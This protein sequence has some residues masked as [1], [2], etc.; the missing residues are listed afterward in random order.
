VDFFNKNRG[1]ISIFLILIMVPMYTGAYYAIDYIRF[2]AARD[3]AY[4]ALE[5]VGNSALANFC[6]PLHDQYGLFAMSTDEEEQS[7]FLKGI[8]EKN[9]NV[10]LFINKGFLNQDVKSFEFKYSPLFGLTNG[11]TLYNAILLREKYAAPYRVVKDFMVKL[12][13]ISNILAVSKA[14]GG[15]SNYIEKAASVEKALKEMWSILPS[16]PNLSVSD[17]ISSLQNAK[18]A[19]EKLTGDVKNLE[20]YYFTLENLIN[21]IKNPAIREQIAPSILEM[22]KSIS[23]AALEELKKS[24]SNDI[25]ELK[26][27]GEEAV[28]SY[29]KS[30]LFKYM[31]SVFGETILSDVRNLKEN[32]KNISMLDITNV[33]ENIENLVIPQMIDS[34]IYE[35]ILAG[36]N[37][38]VN[39]TPESLS[40]I[41]EEDENSSIMYVTREFNK[42]NLTL[43]NIRNITYVADF[44]NTN[45]K[46]V[47]STVDDSPFVAE[48]EY[49]VFGSE[50]QLSNIRRS[51]N[52][53]FSIRVILNSLY[54]FSDKTM[55]AQAQSAA[56]AISSMTGVGSV[57]A[58]NA[59]LITWS[60]AEAY[61][62]LISVAN[63][64]SVPLLKDAGTWMTKIEN[65][66]KL[67]SG[68]LAEIAESSH[69]NL[70][71]MTYEDYLLLFALIKLSSDSGKSS[72]LKRSEVVMQINC[73][74]VDEAFDISKCY[75]GATINVKSRINGHEIDESKT[76]QYQ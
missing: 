42:I 11:E 75:T 35:R 50:N 73:Q 56:A 49:I 45:F 7:E 4:G 36:N 48:A 2:Y 57:L 24:I 12:D 66:P 8:S 27:K 37:I 67:M 59:L 15:V 72:V 10:G 32:L 38:S 16:N 23:S 47:T 52:L 21:E 22:G 18:N 68:E 53:I 1:S 54:A 13:V 28:I 76:I 46:N 5:L 39:E 51:L 69:S 6:Y 64:K 40:N 71:S 62:D 34:N 3:K 61:E 58:K 63:G 14:L 30:V 29:T 25:E 19:I 26:Q 9:L 33:Y 43:D 74:K 44:I 31:E 60:M 41:N 20:S 17:T 70:L 55:N 65:I